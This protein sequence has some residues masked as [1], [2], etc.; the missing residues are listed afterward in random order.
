MNAEAMRGLTKGYGVKI[1]TYLK[2]IIEKLKKAALQGK[3]NVRLR[4]KETGG[5]G[6]SV[7]S[8]NTQRE[9]IKELQKLGYNASHEVDFNQ[10][11]ECY[12]YVS[13]ESDGYE[14]EKEVQND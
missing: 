2:E 8:N 6:Y 11:A 3:T 14:K 4:S 1:D 5:F 7:E 10:F 13:W 12:L 9:I